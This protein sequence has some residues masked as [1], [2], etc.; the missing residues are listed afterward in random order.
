MDKVHWRQAIFF[1]I[2]EERKIAAPI[3]VA[4]RSHDGGRGE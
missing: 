3:Q 4:R 1:A 2:L